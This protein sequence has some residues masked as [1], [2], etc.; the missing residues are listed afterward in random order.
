MA[1]REDSEALLANAC[2]IA[3][4]GHPVNIVPRL[5][6]FRRRYA[7]WENYFASV[8]NVFDSREAAR[9]KLSNL[10]AKEEMR[11]LLTKIEL[12]AAGLSGLTKLMK[13]LEVSPAITMNDV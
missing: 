4:R 13:N 11:D 5:R 2:P 6:A 7:V 12:F 8:A 1:I 3:K 9:V 10:W